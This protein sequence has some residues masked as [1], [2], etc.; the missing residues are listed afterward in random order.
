MVVPKILKLPPKKSPDACCQDCA[1]VGLGPARVWADGSELCGK[2]G[3]V[4][5]VYPIPSDPLLESESSGEYQDI[6]SHSSFRA[7]KNAALAGAGAADARRAEQRGGA[8]GWFE[9]TSL[10]PTVRL[11]LVAYCNIDQQVWS[12]GDAPERTLHL[13]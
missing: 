2:R 7:M 10:H 13:G 5:S 6:Y 8:R 12:N 11:S 9:R 1:Q 4:R 3:T